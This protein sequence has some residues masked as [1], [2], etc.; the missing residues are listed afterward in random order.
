MYMFIFVQLLASEI[1]LFARN[2]L[3][4]DLRKQSKETERYAAMVFLSARG[5][6]SAQRR[7]MAWDARSGRLSMQ[8]LSALVIYFMSGKPKI[9]AYMK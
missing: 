6:M 9:D 7:R 5:G 8:N 4:E 1:K 2:L 3:N